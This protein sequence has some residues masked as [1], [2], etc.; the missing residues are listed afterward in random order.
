MIAHHT[1]TRNRIADLCRSIGDRAID[2]RFNEFGT[3]ICAV[4]LA[5]V[6]VLAAEL[7]KELE[8]AK[9]QGKLTP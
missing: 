7:V 8:T 2:I 5:A 4:A 1:C 3:P 6:Q 9:S